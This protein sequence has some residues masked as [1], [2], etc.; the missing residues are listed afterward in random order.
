MI[1]KDSPEI[2]RLTHLD[3][4]QLH[5]KLSWELERLDQ[6]NVYRLEGEVD[7]DELRNLIVKL[8]DGTIIG[9][10]HPYAPTSST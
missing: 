3:F 1:T 5:Q 10:R 7:M 9:A 8:L 6:F 4:L 2:A